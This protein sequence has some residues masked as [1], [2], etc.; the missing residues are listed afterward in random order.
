MHFVKDLLGSILFP[1]H[2]LISNPPSKNWKTQVLNECGKETE[3]K[4]LSPH[5][6]CQ[7]MC[8]LLS[9]N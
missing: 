7:S 3:H 8:G 6:S 5:L 1:P 2:S 4:V 9:E